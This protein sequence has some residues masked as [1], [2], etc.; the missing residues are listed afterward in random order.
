L[1]GEGACANTNCETRL[2]VKK[3]QNNILKIPELLVVIE[4][5]VYFLSVR[6]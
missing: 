5:P 1:T 3:Q 6:V 2:L 4:N